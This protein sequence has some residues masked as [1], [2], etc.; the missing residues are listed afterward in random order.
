MSDRIRVIQNAGWIIS[1][2]LIKAII[3][4]IVTAL[5]ARYLGPSQYGLLSYAESIVAFAIPITKLGFDSIMV[6]EIV[7]RPEEA[8]ETICSAVFFSFLSA[9]LCMLGIYFFA[10]LV[11][12]GETTTIIV[13][14]LYSIL[15]IFQGIELIQY[16]FQAML[17]SRY[18]SLVI[19][20]SYAIVGTV[21]LALI[22]LKAKIYVFAFLCS[23]EYLFVSVALLFLFQ[24][25][26]NQKLKFSLSCGL[27]MINVSKYYI[28]SALLGAIYNNTDRVMLKIFLGERDTGIY[29]AAHTCAG[30]TSFVFIAIIDSMRPIIFESSKKSEE[31]FEKRIEILYAIIIFSS[32]IQNLLISGFAPTIIRVL[33]G[34]AFSDSIL[35][36]R[37]AVWFTT[38]SYIGTVRNIWILSEEKQK[39]LWRII[40]SGAILNVLLN[41]VFI[42]IWGP[43]GAALTTLLSQIFSNIITGYI[44][45]DLKK[46]NTII[47]RSLNPINIFE[48]IKNMKGN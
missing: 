21:Q 23:V 14:V 24:K 1:C 48:C 38:F 37:I 29:S 28:L 15:L 22:H 31:E 20:I 47:L 6:H 3:T 40:G 35:V 19:L 34:E 25:K 39:Y 17:L 33:Y 10:I 30:M 13:C 18:N 16:W 42:P 46:N 5:T 32:L 11:N 26:S 4:I 12:N 2:K 8:G 41:Y 44:I 45:S 9:L 43:C 27:R 36:L 7:S